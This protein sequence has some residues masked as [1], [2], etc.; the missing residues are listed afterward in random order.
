MSDDDNWEN[1]L[2]DEKEIVVKKEGETFEVEEIVQ[3]EKPIPKPAPKDQKN[4]PKAP[5]DKKKAATTT[6][7]ERDPSKPLTDKEKEELERQIRVNQQKDIASMFGA[8]IGK[9][10]LEYD[11]QSEADYVNFA[12]VVYLKL[13]HAPS[14]KYMISF[15]NSLLQQ[16]NEKFRSEDLQEVQDKTTV[17]INAKIKEE[18]GKDN[19]K[20]KGELSRPSDQS[21]NTDEEGTVRFG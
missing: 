13:E 8:D 4:E 14:R 5:K 9:S 6:A 20:K 12:K 11:L 19:K 21:R 7:V 15:V 10:L 16:M 18:K 17:L 2:E 3:V 1:L